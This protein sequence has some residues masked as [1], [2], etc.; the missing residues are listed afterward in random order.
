MPAAAAGRSLPRSVPPAL[1]ASL[2]RFMAVPLLLAPP[3]P[4]TDDAGDYIKHSLTTAQAATF[5]AWSALEFPRGLAAA[6]QGRAVLREVVWAADYL[7][8]CHLAP[9]RFVGLIGDPG[10]ELLHK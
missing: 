2:P 10:V 1:P 8:A 5:L 6:G 4:D 7:A 9:F 3:F